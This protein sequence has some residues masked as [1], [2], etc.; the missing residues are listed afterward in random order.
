MWASAEEIT[1]PTQ[2]QEGRAALLNSGAGKRT[3]P[4][5]KDSSA[6]GGDGLREPGRTHC[7]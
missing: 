2:Q 6:P 4:G 7:F 5:I 1:F 3:D